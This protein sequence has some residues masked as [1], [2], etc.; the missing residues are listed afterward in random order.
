M[1][2]EEMTPE[3]RDFF[4]EAPIAYMHTIVRLWAQMEKLGITQADYV[5]Y[6]NHAYTENGL[7]R[8]E[9]A[10]REAFL[11]SELKT[12]SRR[13]AACG[14]VMKL[15]SV[16]DSPKNQ[17]GGDFKSLWFCPDMI[18]CGETVYSNLTAME[19]AE[20]YGLGEIFAHFNYTGTREE[21]LKK[22]EMERE[23]L[24]KIWR[25]PTE[26]THRKWRPPRLITNPR[27]APL[28]KKRR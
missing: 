11:V 12:K 2:L 3:Q 5:E 17:V 9:Q 26:H 18:G 7:V 19:E 1:K 4:L 6:F 14:R 16:N 25:R 13:C 24:K 27:F 8:H 22:I 10:R 21:L 28:V 15:S 20:K 23:E